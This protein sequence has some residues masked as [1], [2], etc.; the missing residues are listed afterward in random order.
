MGPPGPTNHYRYYP[1]YDYRYY[2]E[3]R[4]PYYD[5]DYYWDHDWDYDWSD[6]YRNEV[7]ADNVGVLAAYK[8]GLAEGKIEGLKMADQKSMQPDVPSEPGYTGSMGS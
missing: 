3:Y 7:V 2:P 4:W 6:Y 5:N 8:Q 1:R